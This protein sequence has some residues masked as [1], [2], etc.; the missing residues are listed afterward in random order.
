MSRRPWIERALLFGLVPFWAVATILHVD[1]Q[2]SPLPFAWLPVY[3]AP[4][5]GP[6]DFPRVLSLWPDTARSPDSLAPGDRLLAVG[7]HSLAGAGR[8]TVWMRAFPA[9]DADGVVSF[10]VAPR[11]QRTLALRVVRAA[12]GHLALAVALG[13]TGTFV[14][15]RVRNSPAARGYAGAS[16][17]Y[18]IH[19]SSLYGG[20]PW[21][22]A[23]GVWLVIVSGAL[24]PPLMLR[25]ALLFPDSAPR[26]ARWA[27]LAP[28]ALAITGPALYVWIFGIPRL[29]LFGFQYASALFTAGIAALL[30][31]LAH[32]YWVASARGRRQ[33]KWVMW[34]FVAGT[35]PSLV[36]S[37]V[38]ASRPELRGVYEATLAFGVLIPACILVALMRD[39]LFDI[40]RLITTTATYTLLA[41]LLIGT[42]F[43]V[44]P[45]LARVAAE[46]TGLQETTALWVFAI[47]VAAPIPWLAQR[48]RTRLERLLFREQFEVEESLREFRAQIPSFAKPADL[49][50]A[51]GVEVGRRIRLE[52]SALFARAEEAFVPISAHGNAIPPA[53][54]AD[55]ALAALLSDRQQ[56]ITLEQWRSWA[57]RGLLA[58]AD[59][60]ALET[61]GAA[62]ILPLV[63]AGPLEAFLLL[64]DKRSGEL[65]SR[66]EVA[67]LESLVERAVVALD[68]FRVEAVRADERRLYTALARYAPGSV[69]EEL[70]RGGEVAPGEREVTVMFVDVRGYTSFSQAREAPQIFDFVN[71]Y[72]TTVS[73]RVRAQGGSIVEFHGDGLMA[74]FGAPAD[75]ADK[76]RCAVRAALSVVSAF[77]RENLYPG[78][79]VGV[80]VATGPAYVGD[81][82]S[83]DRKIWG[84]IGN[85]TNLAARLQGLTRDH[86]A[87]IAIDALTQ[88][89]AG[90]AC[91]D[92]QR[93]DGVSL[94]GRDEL[95]SVWLLPL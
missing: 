73:E 81:I 61:F 39:N 14:L 66:A 93:R 35:L 95:F 27:L 12:W 13:L 16:L 84:V 40:D 79:S 71:A 32:N 5:P 56:P 31:V 55:G 53:F 86:A 28:W 59:R 9:A 46:R 70:A 69:A 58:H 92:F 10:A 67:M 45:P 80:G 37:A 8:L 54:D 74:A 30:A 38:A 78:M 75:L 11:A 18:S 1:R 2:L 33:L 34:G 88:Q 47:A 63:R 41:P 24:Y 29:G 43:Q 64:G 89:R 25:A 15:L 52:R 19:M 50:N 82:Q 23:A 57:R 77:Q 26:P 4:A 76:E 51:L 6:A 20:L 90:G 85:T 17:L 60:A 22:T 65:F 42:L 91:D 62:L 68:Q 94:K 7:G 48:L 83:V 72:T 36:A 21:Q 3:L 87:S 49:L 44:V